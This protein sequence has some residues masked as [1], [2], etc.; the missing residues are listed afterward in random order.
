MAVGGGSSTWSVG[1]GGGLQ[2]AYRNMDTLEDHLI[3][4]PKFMESDPVN[5]RAHLHT[6]YMMDE[7]FCMARFR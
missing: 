6:C 7:A 1:G 3:S 5:A 4:L 2:E